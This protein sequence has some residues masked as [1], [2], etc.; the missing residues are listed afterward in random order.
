MLE[1]DGEAG[2]EVGVVVGAL[3]EGD[4]L[5]DRWWWVWAAVGAG[6]PEPK[7]PESRAHTPTASVVVRSPCLMGAR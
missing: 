3:V 2:D 4:V 7:H 5:C 1:V 6:E